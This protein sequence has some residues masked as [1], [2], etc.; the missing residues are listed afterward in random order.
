MGPA[1]SRLGA[2]HPLFALSWHSFF[3]GLVPLYAFTPT[4]ELFSFKHVRADPEPVVALLVFVSF[5]L[6]S[7]RQKM[8]ATGVP[9]RAVLVMALEMLCHDRA[10]AEQGLPLLCA[11]PAL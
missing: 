1:G 7:S 6:H 10:S 3:V 5:S 8:D 9:P 4:N 11:V 2:G